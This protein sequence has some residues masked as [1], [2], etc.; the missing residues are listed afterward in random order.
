MQ[1]RHLASPP[2]DFLDLAGGEATLGQGVVKEKSEA[3]ASNWRQSL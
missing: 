2:P 1:G 3:P